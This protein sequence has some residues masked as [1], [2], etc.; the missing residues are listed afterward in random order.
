M[1]SM[2]KGFTLIELMIVVA[3]I[4]ILAAIAFL[5]IKTISAR[6]QASEAFSSTCRTAVSEITNW[7]IE[8]T[9]SSGLRM[10]VVPNAAVVAQ[11]VTS[12]CTSYTSRC[13]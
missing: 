8:V 3:I 9:G 5:L 4:G 12:N 6:A 10:H 7:L 11:P 1:K 2:Q 13:S